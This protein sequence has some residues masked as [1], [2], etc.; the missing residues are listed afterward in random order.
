MTQHSVLLHFES[1]SLSSALRSIK[2][3]GLSRKYSA[4]NMMEI[5][6][7]SGKGDKVLLIG[8]GKTQVRTCPSPFLQ[9]SSFLQGSTL[10]NLREAADDVQ[11]WFSEFQPHYCKTEHRGKRLELRDNYLIPGIPLDV[12]IMFIT[13]NLDFL[14]FSVCLCICIHIHIY[15]HTHICL[16]LG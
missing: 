2:L 13:L 11:M 16:I 8:T 14:I 5:Y 10:E 9:L 15:R 1:F 12:T 4:T 3:Q 6:C 7:L